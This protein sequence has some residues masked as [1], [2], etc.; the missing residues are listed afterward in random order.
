M[1]P[2]VN[3]AVSSLVAERCRNGPRALAVVRV[4]IGEVGGRDRSRGSAQDVVADCQEEEKS[5]KVG[6]YFYQ[7][8]YMYDVRKRWGK[9]YPKTRRTEGRLRDYDKR[10]EGPEKSETI[11]DVIEVWLQQKV[12]PWLP[13]GDDRF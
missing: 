6:M 10:G 9:R 4:G 13:D 1:K 3:F 2:L 8:A 7:G 5:V 11:A 12:A